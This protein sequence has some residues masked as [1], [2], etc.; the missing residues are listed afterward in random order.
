MIA[1]GRW[2][3]GAVLGGAVVVFLAG[4]V[5]YA[6]L[7]PAPVLSPAVPGVTAE[8]SLPPE[9]P[10]GRTGIPDAAAEPAHRSPAAR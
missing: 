9:A 5:S 1:G 8:A 2:P 6:A 7:R 10:V 3:L 4:G